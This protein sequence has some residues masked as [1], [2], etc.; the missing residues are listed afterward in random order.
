[1]KNPKPL[2]SLI[3]FAHYVVV[4]LALTLAFPALATCSRVINVPISPIGLSVI[5]KGEEVSGVYPEV[6]RGL[7]RQGC[8][9]GFSIVPRARL[10]AMFEAGKADLLVPATKTPRR[11]EHGVFIPLVQSRAVIIGLADAPAKPSKLT[12]LLSNKQLRVALVRGFDFGPSYQLLLSGLEK[13]GRL[14][15]ATDALAVAR[16]MQGGL[17]DVT[18]MAPSI[19]V[20]AL[21]NDARSK[22]LANGLQF[23]PVEEFPWG[24]SGIYISRK[25]VGQKDIQGLQELLQN[26]GQR[27]D[28]WKA[29]Q[30][31]YRAEVL[32]GSIRP[33]PPK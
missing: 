7:E 20:G 15:L 1:M 27:G 11:D 16:L 25:A 17:V 14:V 10:E 13:Q 23:Y 31:Y 28:V 4:L 6:L 8:M 2:F 21:E 12:D 19:F 22:A 3:R 18:V 30:H 33:L 5:V 9:F 32:S 26:S 29:F 24:E